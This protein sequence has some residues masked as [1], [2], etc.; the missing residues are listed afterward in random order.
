MRPVD[1]VEDAAR[2]DE[3]DVVLAVGAALPAIEEPESHGSVT[4]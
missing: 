1:L 2:V 4:V 3:K